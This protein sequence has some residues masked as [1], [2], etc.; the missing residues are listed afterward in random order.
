MDEVVNVDLKRR[1]ERYDQLK[2]IKDTYTELLK[3]K[4][5]TMRKLAETVGSDDRQTLALRQQYAMEHLHYLQTELRGVQSQKRKLEAQTQG[6]PRPSEAGEST[7]EPEPPS[8]QEIDRLVDAHPAVVELADQLAE[9]QQRLEVQCG[10]TPEALPQRPASEPVVAEPEQSRQEPPPVAVTPAQGGTPRSDPAGPPTGRT[11][12]TGAE[13]QDIGRELAM[14]ADLEQQLDGEIKSI[15]IVNQ[16]LTSNTLDLQTNKDE[17]AQMEARRD[18]GRPGGRGAQ[19]RARGAPRIR[20]IDDATV[21]RTRDD[22]K[23]YMMVGMVTFGS[24]FG[25]LFGIAF[26]ELQS[27]KVDT[28]DEVPV[29]LG[30]AVVG[31]LP[32]LPARNH[33]RGAIARRETDKDRYWRNVL[34][35]SVDATRT[36]LLHA[37]RTGSYRV[38]M[39]TSAVGGEG[40]TSLASYLATSLARSGLRTL[41]I[42]ADLR[43]P[44]MHRLFDLPPAPGLSELLRGEVELDD[45]LGGDGRRG[46]DAPAP[47]GDA[48]ARPSASSRRAG[49]P[50][51]STRLK[52]RFD[53]IIVDSSPILPVADAMLIAQHADAALFS[54]FRD[55]S[56]K[57]KVKAACRAAPAPGRAGPGRRRDR[58]PRRCSTATVTTM[59]IRPISGLPE[60][61]AVSSDEASLI[62]WESSASPPPRP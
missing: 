7:A 30:L 48:T 37:A 5:E 42:D 26:L 49:S 27:R 39:I 47:P 46:P 57:T 52:Q 53:F 40:K 17:V 23:R 38:M 54:I 20:L 1:I 36:L 2:K 22:K 51:C 4:R 55:V 34:L 11:S 21:P 19:R 10:Q 58:G 6:R 25:G 12:R 32:I 29:E 33:H 60:S 15:T 41:L 62:P 50:R 31:A 45:A 18:Q 35:E 13:G 14:L 61:V 28:A 56:R 9:Q 43:S 3:K 59:R 16:S 44:M 24:F 8:E